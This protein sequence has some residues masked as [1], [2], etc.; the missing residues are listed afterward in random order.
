MFCLPLRF[1][2]RLS[3]IDPREG[4]VRNGDIQ[5]LTQG[6]PALLHLEHQQ[7]V[8]RDVARNSLGTTGLDTD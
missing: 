6:L 8:S 4:T 5:E 2:H 3:V 7:L 1:L